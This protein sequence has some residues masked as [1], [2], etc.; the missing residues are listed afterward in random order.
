MRKNIF[1]LGSEGVIGKRL[2]VLL[3]EY[4]EISCYDLA[5]GHDL[6]DKETVDN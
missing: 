4:F 6:T 5:L 1:V 3:N 2:K